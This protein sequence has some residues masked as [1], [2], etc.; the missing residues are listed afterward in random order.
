MC[1]RFNVNISLTSIL[2]KQFDYSF[3][4][5]EQPLRAQHRKCFT[6]VSLAKGMFLYK[7]ECTRS[8]LTIAARS[9]SALKICWIPKN[10]AVKCNSPHRRSLTWRWWHL[11]PSFPLFPLRFGSFLFLDYCVASRQSLCVFSWKPFCL[12]TIFLHY[13]PVP[14]AFQY[15]F[16]SPS[17]FL[18]HFLS[19]Y[20]TPTSFPLF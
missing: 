7:T 16:F 2:N 8:P 14:S 9:S 5:R 12:L 3:L 6:S 19:P 4:Y 13:L 10:P 18:F 17:P 1:S 11:P 20:S 15:V